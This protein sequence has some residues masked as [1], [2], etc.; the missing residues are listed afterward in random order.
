M[1]I[2]LKVQGKQR[3]KEKVG[4]TSTKISV[5]N[6]CT[7]KSLSRQAVHLEGCPFGLGACY[8]NRSQKV[9]VDHGDSHIKKIA[10][11]S[12]RLVKNMAKEKNGC[13]NFI[14]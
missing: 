4:L 5:R 2:S 10:K 13:G 12:W 3:I 6:L 9:I 1:Q 7:L 14:L 11:K 8:V